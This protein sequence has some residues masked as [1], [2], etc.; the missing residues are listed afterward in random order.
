MKP[1][2]QVF[3]SIF[4]GLLFSI[5][6]PNELYSFGYPIIAFFAF[7]PFYLTFTKCKSYKQAFLNGFIFTLTTH[8]CSSYWLAFFKD[9][10][11]FTL[12]GSAL[13]TAFLGGIFGQFIYLPFSK[14]INKLNSFK[15]NT[16]L[17][18]RPS[19]R[20]I[21]FS[22]IYTL[23]EWSKSSGFL[24]YPW[25][26]V[27]SAMF[28]FPQIRQ[29]A[30]ITGTY[31][32]TFIVICINSALAEIYY[33]IEN[34]K[35][36]KK[37]KIVEDYFSAL[38]LIV[39]LFIST[40]IYG[41]I[42]YNK[43]RTPIKT[44]STVMIQQNCDPWTQ[45][46]DKEM[47]NISQK[48]TTSALDELEKEDKKAELI[49]WSEGVLLNP[50]EI[51]YSHYKKYPFES[52]LIPFIKKCN[53]PF[54][55]GGSTKKTFQYKDFSYNKYYNSALVFDKN[56][57]YRGAYAKLHLVPFAE[58]IPFA[59][60]PI[61]KE[62][63][64]EYLNFSAG[65]TKGEYLTLFNIPCSWY[66]APYDSEVKVFDLSL[67]EKIDKDLQETPKV[68]VATPICF[69]DAF[70]DVIRPLYY[71]GAELFLNITD[72]SWSLKKSSEYQHFVVASY[73]AI[74]Y[75]TTLARSTNSG[76]SVV[77][78]PAGKILTDQ[79]LF[80]QSYCI[81]DIPIFERQKTTFAVFGN[82]IIIV[83]LGFFIYSVCFDFKN[84]NLEVCIRPSK[85]IKLK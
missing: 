58:I 62:F 78:D 27:S 14:K 6:I 71:N 74:E 46:T 72:D 15:I 49:I 47:I 24:G 59:D 4:S 10:A 54:I 36:V 69:D 22:S 8:L 51:S 85:K 76:Y 48:L 2:L 42:E 81:Y 64:Q 63:I 41:T 55:I 34:Y 53:T 79:P 12:G 37:S 61:V 52:P 82:W 29:L 39:V 17:F 18:C 50:F 7:I 80:E 25:G 35:H 75:R 73:R 16:E 23:Y 77:I 11:F 5:A 1:F 9:F 32:V 66:N 70:T 28:N 20:I 57:D 84:R 45:P 33:V 26:T 38:N 67:N 43:E 83:I 40:L 3:Y 30:A 19:F 13:Y 56:G 44:L 68:K 60:N 65:W 31:G 21:Y